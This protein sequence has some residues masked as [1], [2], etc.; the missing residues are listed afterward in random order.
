MP[1]T[2]IGICPQN[3]NILRRYI[4][5]VGDNNYSDNFNPQSLYTKKEKEKPDS[6]R[7]NRSGSHHWCRHLTR[8]KEQFD[9]NVLGLWLY[10][11][12]HFTEIPF[13]FYSLHA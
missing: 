7:L 10:F 13:L 1:I 9:G 3:L 12:F 4:E 6:D 2:K 8:I 11:W 5:N